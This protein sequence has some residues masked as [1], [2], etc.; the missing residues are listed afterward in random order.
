MF[1]VHSFVWCDI[2]EIFINCCI[3]NIFSIAKKH[4]IAPD[5]LLKK[6]KLLKKLDII[7]SKNEFSIVYVYERIQYIMLSI[8]IMIITYYYSI[9]CNNNCSSA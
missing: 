6:G 5:Y 2:F 4:T 3:L 8:I 1:V 7:T 9:C